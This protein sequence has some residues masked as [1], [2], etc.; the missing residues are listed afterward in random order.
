VTIAPE[1]AVTWW[2]VDPFGFD[3]SITFDNAFSFFLPNATGATITFHAVG[4]YG[5]HS[6]FGDH[7]SVIVSLPAPAAL[8]L[9]SFRLEGT[10]FL[11]D[12]TGL[13]PGKTNVLEAST[14]LITWTAI[15]TNLAAST[16]QTFTNSTTLPRRFFRLLE[17]P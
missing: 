16:T 4:T 6:D 10:K 14:N 17:L 3:V 11:F 13:T 2:N 1:E 12:A 15:Q 8:A 5:F 9:E 7:G